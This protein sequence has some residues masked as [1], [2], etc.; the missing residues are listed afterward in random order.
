M[1]RKTFLHQEITGGISVL[2][3]GQSGKEELVKVD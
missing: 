1:K 3:G 2:T